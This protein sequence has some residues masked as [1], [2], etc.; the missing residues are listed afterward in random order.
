MRVP[1]RQPEP[2]DRLQLEP[3]LN[4]TG[5]LA[6]A[7]LTQDRRICNLR[8]QP[9]NQRSVLRRLIECKHDRTWCNDLVEEIDWTV[10]VSVVDT[11]VLVGVAVRDI[12]QNG[13]ARLVDYWEWIEIEA[14]SVR[15]K[16]QPEDEDNKA[17][18]QEKGEEY[19]ADEHRNPGGQALLDHTGVAT[20]GATGSGLR[21]RLR[22]SSV[23]LRCRTRHGW[24]LERWACG[25]VLVV[26]GGYVEVGRGF[27]VFLLVWFG[28]KGGKELGSTID[29]CLCFL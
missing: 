9:S 17:N 6:A 13:G 26:M 20:G 22:S 18:N 16:A 24:V 4:L 1:C 8:Q 28:L 10:H 11:D 19:W 29:V 5:Q 7:D 3:E 21:C 25:G 12:E 2:D 27:F 23:L 15:S 14:G